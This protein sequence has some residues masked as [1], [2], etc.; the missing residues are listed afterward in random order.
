MKIPRQIILVPLIWALCSH[1]LAKADTI[2]TTLNLTETTGASGQYL[3]ADF[4]F[5]VAFSHI[6]SV[7]LSFTI[8][9]G[10][11]AIDVAGGYFAVSSQLWMV[12]HSLDTSPTF[13]Y[14][15]PPGNSAS[16]LGT[17]FLSVPAGQVQQIGLFPPVIFYG[18][19]DSPWPGFLY[20][21]KG[22]LAIADLRYNSSGFAPVG[23]VTTTTSWELPGEISNFNLTITGTVVPEPMT[24]LLLAEGAVP[25]MICTHLARR[26]QFFSRKL[27][28]SVAALWGGRFGLPLVR[29]GEAELRIGVINPHH[30][31]FGELTLQ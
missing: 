18:P 1:T 30:A 13:G 8:P 9:N 28:P 7:A 21:G 5:H 29:T 6:D 19:P 15:L 3:S 16:D 11:D 24:I 23:P 17:Q 27:R 22:S 4:D 2:T 26:K 14:F 10:Y 20:S 25:T 31:A 12:L